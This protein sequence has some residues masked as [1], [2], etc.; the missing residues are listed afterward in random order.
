VRTLASVSFPPRAGRSVVAL[1]GAAIASVSAACATANPSRAPLV[2]DRPDFTESTETMS[3]G[4]VQLEGGH[5][6][7]RVATDKVNTTGELLLRIGLAP[8]AEVRI[9]PG[10]Y[11]KITS[12][13]GDASGREDGALGV[14]LRLHTPRDEKPSV[15]PAVSLLVASSVPTGSDAFRQNRP[16]PELK[17]ASAWT[18][19]D[20]VGLATNVNV[21]RPRDANGRYTELAASVSFGLELTPR[22]GAYAE[23]FGFA[24]Q[25]DGVG[26]THYANTGFTASLTPDFQ[27]DVRGGVGLNGSAPDYFVGVGLVR[28]W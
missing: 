9:E 2:S 1:A 18:I 24:P 11:A 4:E 16:Q 7:E 27:L 23:V 22:F 12:P 5:T 25:L 6:F 19:T 10:S 28:R 15:V 21:A 14:K 3:R 17:L 20:R 13:L 8:R 26:R